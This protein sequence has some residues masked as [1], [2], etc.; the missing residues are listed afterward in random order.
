MALDRPLSPAARSVLQALMEPMARPSDCTAL[1]LTARTKLDT[2]LSIVLRE[3][4]SFDPPLVISE[5]DAVIGERVWFATAAGAD[6][7]DD[8]RDLHGQRDSLMHR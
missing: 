5:V 7:V 4:E 3:L 6:A 2:R 8:D 1:S